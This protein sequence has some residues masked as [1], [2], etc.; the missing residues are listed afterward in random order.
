MSSVPK[1]CSRL[2]PAAKSGVSSVNSHGEKI[3]PSQKARV[4]STSTTAATMAIL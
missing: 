4:S 2:G 3:G 1:G